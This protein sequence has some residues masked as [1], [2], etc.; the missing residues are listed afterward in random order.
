MIDGE[1]DTWSRLNVKLH[2]A[3]CR[4]CR[5]FVEQMRITAEVAHRAGE[6]EDLVLSDDIKAALAQRQMRSGRTT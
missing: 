3:I 5:A 6:S 2:L 1:L 4:G